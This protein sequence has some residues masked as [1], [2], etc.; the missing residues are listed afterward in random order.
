MRSRERID[1]LTN[2]DMG[3]NKSERALRIIVA[4]L[5]D[6]SLRKIEDCEVAHDAWAKLQSLYAGK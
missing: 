4:G 1:A 3:T 5:R 6:N 2:A